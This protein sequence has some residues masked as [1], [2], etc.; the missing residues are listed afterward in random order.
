MALFSVQAG[1]KQM[2]LVRGPKQVRQRLRAVEASH[3]A[4]MV[5]AW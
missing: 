4:F 2:K 5:A 3:V 1:F